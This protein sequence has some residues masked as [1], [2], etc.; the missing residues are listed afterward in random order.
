MLGL[1]SDD[2]DP[3]G[4]T[5]VE[6]APSRIAAVVAYFPPTDL[7]T[8]AG[9]NERFPALNF[10]PT[11]GE[12]VSPIIHVDADEPPT[13]LMHGDADTLVPIA[14]SQRLFAVFQERGVT[15]EFIT[16]P[17]QGHGFRGE[18]AQRGQQEVVEWFTEH[19][20]NAAVAAR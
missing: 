19:L 9:P 10:D 14:H 20:V 13:L 15:S 6:S 4:S 1:T 5:P 12:S 16:F 8:W 11:L 7:R 17:G 3:A 18:D 2:G